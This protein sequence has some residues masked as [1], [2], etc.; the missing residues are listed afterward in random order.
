MAKLTR[1]KRAKPNVA[2][3]WLPE[4]KR[5]VR[6]ESFKIEGFRYPL[7]A[8]RVFRAKDYDGRARGY[9]TVMY[10]Q[11]LH[12]GTIEIHT[13]WRSTRLLTPNSKAQLECKRPE[14]VTAITKEVRI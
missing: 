13:S 10:I 8:G 3:H 1:R 11:E 14:H 12:D 7:E 5:P 2:Y 6:L 9:H 4:D